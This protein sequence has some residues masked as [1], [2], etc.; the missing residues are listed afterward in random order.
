MW[1]VI[2]TS[3][4]STIVINSILRIDNDDDDDDDENRI[5][6]AAEATSARAA[7]EVGAV[8]VR[9][10]SGGLV[11]RLVADLSPQSSGNMTRASGTSFICRHDNLP[12]DEMKRY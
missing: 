5:A 4:T 2:T 1:I 7:V 8:E 9:Q 10:S 6:N 11:S 3:S 12:E